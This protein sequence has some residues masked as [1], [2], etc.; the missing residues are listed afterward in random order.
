VK[1]K[2]LLKIG[3]FVGMFGLI[4]NTSFSQ[5]AE[6]AGNKPIKNNKAVA[7]VN[8]SK[9]ERSAYPRLED[10]AKSSNSAAEYQKAKSEWIQKYPDAY[11]KMLENKT[12]T[13]VTRD[14]LNKLPAERAAYIKNHPDLY[15]I[16]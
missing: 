12:I 15:E 2:E 11:K 4:S 13:V 10:F 3:I 5:R 16:K 6:N 1:K 9:A 14:E 8:D 7:S